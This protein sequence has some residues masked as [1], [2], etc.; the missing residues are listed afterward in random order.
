MAPTAWPP[1]LDTFNYTPVIVAA[2]ACALAAVWHCGGVR[3][4]YSGPARM[5]GARF[6]VRERAVVARVSVV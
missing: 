6:E 3:Q 1:E 2:F 4:R 5:D